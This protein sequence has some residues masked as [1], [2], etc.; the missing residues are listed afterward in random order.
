MRKR[1]RN[2]VD[3]CLTDGR[4]LPDVIDVRARKIAKSANIDLDHMPDMQHKPTI[5]DK[6]NDGVVI[7][8]YCNGCLVISG[9][10]KA[11]NT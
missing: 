7:T 3:H 6:L 9:C 11:G 1:I 4:H 5:A 8:Q 2:Q 10:S